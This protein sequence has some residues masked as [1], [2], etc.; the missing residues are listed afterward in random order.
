MLHVVF[1]LNFVKKC[2]CDF[3]KL[4]NDIA[5]SCPKHQILPKKYVNKFNQILKNL[6]TPELHC[7]KLYLYL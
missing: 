6:F 2:K 7:F 3:E 1:C 4:K 5:F